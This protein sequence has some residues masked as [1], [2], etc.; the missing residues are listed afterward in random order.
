MRSALGLVRDLATEHDGGISANVILADTS[1]LLAIRY[2]HPGQPPTLYMRR[3]ES[4]HDGTWIASEPLDEHK[5]WDPIPPSS[6][7]RVDAVGVRIEPLF[8]RPERE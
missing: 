5:G 7:V 4:P 8:D 3:E 1:G 6:L 2:A